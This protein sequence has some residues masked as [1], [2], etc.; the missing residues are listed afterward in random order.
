MDL[1][2]NVTDDAGAV[3]DVLRR[4]SGILLDIGCGG[5]KQEGHVG[6]DIRPLPGV[7]IVWD[8]ED[9]PWPLSDESV[10]RAIASHVVEH[11]NPHKF[12]F[13]RWMDEVWRVMKPGGQLMIAVPHG[14]SQGYLQDPTHCNPCNEQTWTYFDP[15]ANGGVLYNIYK[16]KPW[17]IAFLEWSPAANIEVVMVKRE[18]SP[19]P[20]GVT[21]ADAV[22]TSEELA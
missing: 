7:D 17:R 9:I 4:Q 20:L 12:G 2:V 10:L 16:P 19:P 3:D 22:V 14:S 18:P 6:M 1:S 5:N 21:V 13:V 11:I 8:F 15:E